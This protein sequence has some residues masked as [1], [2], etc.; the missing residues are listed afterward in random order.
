MSK[1]GNWYDRYVY[2]SRLHCELLSG[3]LIVCQIYKL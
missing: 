2:M 1:I 3:F